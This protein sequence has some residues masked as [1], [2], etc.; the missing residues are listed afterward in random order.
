MNKILFGV[1][2]V[3]A[4]L[5]GSTAL[6]GSAAFAGQNDDLVA[7]L[8]ATEQ[9]NAAMR[10]KNAELAAAATAKPVTI[11]D[12]MADFIGAYAADL[13][14][15]YK[16]PPPVEPGRF[17][18]WVEGGAIWSGGDSFADAG[19]LPD[20][21]AVGF[22]GYTGGNVGSI[23][24]L[25]DLN[26][27]VGW[28][29]ATGFDYKFAASPWHVSGQFRYGESGS[30]SGSASSSGTLD[31]AILGLLNAEYYIGCYSP[32]AGSAFP[33][34]FAGNTA[35]C[36]G[37]AS[38]SESYKETHWLADLAL[39]Y[40]IVG[41][42]SYV[43]VKGGLRIAEFVGTFSSNS[44]QTNFVNLSS[45][46]LL[47]GTGFSALSISSNYSLTERTN[48]I[49]TGPLIGLE[50]SAR[51]MGAWSFDYK[52]DLAVL[53]GTQ[54]EFLTQIYRTTTTPAV[55]G[56]VNSSFASSGSASAYSNNSRFVT[57]LSP[58]IQVGVSYWFTPNWKVGVSY[59]IDALIAVKNQKSADA[60]NLLLP[61]RYWHGPL[62]GFT[63]TF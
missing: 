58:D 42:P 19:T 54:N 52:G 63:G 4:A 38:V 32:I 59:R 56:I 26:P 50:G 18:V 48:F 53:F 36:G 9:E 11:T 25:F 44:S 1:V 6:S 46:V 30:A 61:Q 16:A 17:T 39:G 20:F 21:T 51:F 24:Y 14:V 33:G 13:P 47:G 55:L 34:S 31:P 35:A 2:A 43:Q 49:G 41:G 3:S 5:L 29:A 10:K 40:D 45:P 37:S 28:T 12:K 57:V 62:V 22:T 15:A 27:K 23:P 60:D 7:R 8:N